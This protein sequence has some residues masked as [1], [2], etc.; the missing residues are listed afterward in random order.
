MAIVG[1]A[2]RGRAAQVARFADI[3]ATDFCGAP[4]GAPDEIRA[5]IDALAGLVGT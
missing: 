5:T 4:F 2:V 1:T 3:G